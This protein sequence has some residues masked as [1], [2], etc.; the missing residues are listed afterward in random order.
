MPLDDQAALA[1]AGPDVA[2]LAAAG[3]VEQVMADHVQA[4]EQARG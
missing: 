2:D 4:A 3:D 1:L